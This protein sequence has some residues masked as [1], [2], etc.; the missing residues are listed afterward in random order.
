MRWAVTASERAGVRVGGCT[1]EEQARAVAPPHV[2]EVR[3]L[4]GLVFK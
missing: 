2:K 1:Q 3:L 4:F